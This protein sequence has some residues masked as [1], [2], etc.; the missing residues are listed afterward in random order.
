MKKINKTI[1]LTGSSGVIGKS[2][3]NFLKKKSLNLILLN[4]S[5]KKKNT[6]NLKE[7]LDL[8]FADCIIHLAG[9]DDY[10]SSSQGE[11]K[12]INNILDK[13]VILI[14][15]KLKIPFIIF[16]STNRVY[17]GSIKSFISE[18]TKVIPTSIYSQSKLNTEKKLSKLNSKLAILR[19]PSVLSK[20][21][22]KGL[23]YFLQKKMIKNKVIKIFN[24][25]SLFNNV[26]LQEDLNKMIHFMIMKEKKLKQKEIFNLNSENPIKF[27]EIIKYMLKK[28]NSNSKIIEKNTNFISKT[29][30]N[31]YQKKIFHF[32]AK[33]VK[34]SINSYLNDF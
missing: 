2:L 15:K 24:S 8:G 14:V 26:I 25:Q 5:K 29:Y 13:K 19:L 30:S 9:K 3:K 34:S 6:K 33:S 31:K 32:R 10:N 7:I 16:F 21:S 27:N 20:F 17:E 4:G 1:I 18:N 11:I 28:F 12:K 23:I 22:K